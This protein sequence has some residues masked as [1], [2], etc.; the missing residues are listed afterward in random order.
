VSWGD[1]SSGDSRTERVERMFKM[2]YTRSTPGKAVV[3]EPGPSLGAPA[4]CFTVLSG[5]SRLAGV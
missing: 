4:G 2:L 5:L 3:R 1:R